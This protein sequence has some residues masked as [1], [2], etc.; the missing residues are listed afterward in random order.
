MSYQADFIANLKYY[1]SLKGY[2]QAKL[3][4][5]CGCQAATIGC[6]ECARQFPSFDLLF[7]MTDALEIHPADLFLRNSS[8]SVCN[9]REIM[10]SEFMPYVN[11]FVEEHF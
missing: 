5:L 11:K 1:R 2:S 6:I 7:K 3:A 10:K 8:H 4:E 9:I